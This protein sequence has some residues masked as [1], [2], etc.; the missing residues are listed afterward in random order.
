[1][2][3]KQLKK[4]TRELRNVAYRNKS[5]VKRRRVTMKL[6]G[7]DY[8]LHIRGVGTKSVKLEL[9][10]HYEDIVKDKDDPLNKLLW[11]ILTE[12]YK[13]TKSTTIGERRV[14]L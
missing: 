8:D 14:F 9:F 3:E 6:N 5:N 2:D 10:V 7:C 1:M 11:D 4:E 12:V 13:D